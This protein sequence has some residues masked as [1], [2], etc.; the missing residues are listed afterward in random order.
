MAPAQQD[1]DSIDSHGNERIDGD[2]IGWG[3][4]HLA[5]ENLAG[6]RSTARFQLL[7]QAVKLGG[8]TGG[9]HQRRE[10]VLPGLIK[11][12]VVPGFGRKLKVVDSRL[13]HEVDRS[14]DMTIGVETRDRRSS[15]SRLRPHNINRPNLGPLRAA[16]DAGQEAAERHKSA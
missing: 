13:G 2:L 11:E 15:L 7:S 3:N 4:A 12:P 16:A 14:G 6:C 9:D 8:C 1:L 10:I 5:A